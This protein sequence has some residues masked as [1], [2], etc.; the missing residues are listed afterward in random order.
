M[1][2]V[3]GLARGLFSGNWAETRER[4]WPLGEVLLD[5]RDREGGKGVSAER[6]S[7]RPASLSI[8]VGNKEVWQRK[9]F[10]QLWGIER[11]KEGREEKKKQNAR[12][13]RRNSLHVAGPGEKNR[14][15]KAQP[16]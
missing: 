4:A 9:R 14:A 15:A 16:V 11:K 1:V 3:C 13:D 7:K 10:E 6:A 12:F 8:F 5:R 2:P